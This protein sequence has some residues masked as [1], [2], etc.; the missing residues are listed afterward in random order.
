MESIVP[1]E[2][3]LILLILEHFRLKSS[4]NPEQ[5]PSEEEF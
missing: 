3:K 1:L 5:K 4:F 2:Q